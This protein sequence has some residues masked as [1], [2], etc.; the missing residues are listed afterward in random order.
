MLFAAQTLRALLR[1]VPEARLA[2][3]T[4]GDKRNALAREASA[5][6]M[7]SL[8]A[9][10]IHCCTASALTL[11]CLCPAASTSAG[12]KG[13]QQAAALQADHRRLDQG[14]CV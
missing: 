13:A 8:N 14:S 5:V 4:G 7:V 10:V 1:A 9:A 6:L 12:K 11:A 3:L 2:S